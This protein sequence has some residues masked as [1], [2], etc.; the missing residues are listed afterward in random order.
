MPYIYREPRKVL[1]VTLPR[2]AFDRIKFLG[3][4]IG[5]EETSEII[6]RA[7][8]HYDRAVCAAVERAEIT[9][10]HRDGSVEDFTPCGTRPSE[11]G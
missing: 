8:N 9:A 2:S 4:V 3:K 10:R 5:V 7:L 1:R 11:S 6:L